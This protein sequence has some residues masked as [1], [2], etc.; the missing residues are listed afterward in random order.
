MQQ[1]T[2]EQALQWEIATDKW[3]LL[4]SFLFSQKKL[5]AMYA[6]TVYR[7]YKMYEDHR[8]IESES[9]AVVFAQA[10]INKKV[11]P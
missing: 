11:N 4:K 3:F 2:V 5:S 1:I 10:L 6:N 7:K 9:N 8:V